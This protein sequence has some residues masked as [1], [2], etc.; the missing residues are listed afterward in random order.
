[1]LS[2]KH[3]KM[4]SEFSGICHLHGFCL[5]VWWPE[6][7][8]SKTN[9]ANQF[10]LPLGYFLLVWLPC[11]WGETWCSFLASQDD[12]KQKWDILFV[13]RL[14]SIREVGVY[15]NPWWIQE[16]QDHHSNPIP[17]LS[18]SLQHCNSQWV[19]KYPVHHSNSLLD[20]GYLY[21]YAHHNEAGCS[22]ILT[23]MEWGSML[24]PWLF[25]F[26]DCFY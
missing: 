13:S 6:T 14:A 8:G 23:P 5:F 16:I 9:P 18:A 11:G 25:F 17:N 21:S 12:N 19:R 3:F 20:K 1:M 4:P 10:H 24:L 2:W 26:K 7:V 22:Y 15:L